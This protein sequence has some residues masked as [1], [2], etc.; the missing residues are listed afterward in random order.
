VIPDMI[1]GMVIRHIAVF[2]CSARVVVPVSVMLP[3]PTTCVSCVQERSL[4]KALI[5]E[6]TCM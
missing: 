3:V 6:W 5:R 1:V 4:L 2:P